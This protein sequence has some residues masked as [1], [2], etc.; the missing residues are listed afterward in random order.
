MRRSEVEV[1]LNDRRFMIKGFPD[2]TGQ[3]LIVGYAI[4]IARH[5]AFEYFRRKGR[6]G[7][8]L[9]FDASGDDSKSWNEL[10]DATPTPEQIVAADEQIVVAAEP[11]RCRVT[12]SGPL[13]MAKGR[14]RAEL[15]NAEGQVLAEWAQLENRLEGDWC[16]EFQHLAGLRLR[17]HYV[18]DDGTD[19]T[20]EV[21][22][23]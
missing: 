9:E 12:W 23:K 22:M 11:G 2:P 8:P 21:P 1:E 5:A 19:V 7:P 6:G 10:A 16:E 14:A 13:P 3:G 15:L 4:T 20:W 18:R 17:V